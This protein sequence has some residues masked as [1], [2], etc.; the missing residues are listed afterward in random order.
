MSRWDLEPI[1]RGLPPI[2]N[3]KRVEK[4][5][6]YRQ[7]YCVETTEEAASL[8]ILIIDQAKLR[9]RK[10]VQELERLE[11]QFLEEI[12]QD[13][14]RVRSIQPD[15]TVVFGELLKIH[16]VG[17]SVLFQIKTLEGDVHVVESIQKA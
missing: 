2:K 3:H 6:E 7:I 15:G 13:M 9:H 10:A 17:S 11:N 1:L 8:G 12:K 14:P 16:P 4:G 5:D